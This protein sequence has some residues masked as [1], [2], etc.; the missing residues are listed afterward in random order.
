MTMDSRASHHHSHSGSEKITSNQV[1]SRDWI[2][3]DMSNIRSPQKQRREFDIYSHLWPGY[4]IHTAACGWFS[5]RYSLFLVSKNIC[6]KRSF[7]VILLV[8]LCNLW[9][10]SCQNVDIGVTTE[11]NK[12]PSIPNKLRLMRRHG[13]PIPIRLK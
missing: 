6:S 7:L 5:K 13:L 12:Q 1:R 2:H 8:L 11:H 3:H 9:L 10:Y 4:A